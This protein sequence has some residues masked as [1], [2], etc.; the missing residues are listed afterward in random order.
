MPGPGERDNPSRRVSAVR[1][2][3]LASNGTSSTKPHSSGG[4][5]LTGAAIDRPTDSPKHRALANLCAA[6]DR[7]GHEV[8]LDPSAP[9]SATPNVVDAGQDLLAAACPS[10]GECV[11]SGGG[12]HV[13][14]GDPAIPRVGPRRRSREPTCSAVW[15]ASRRQNASPS[16][17]WATG[18]SATSRSSD[19]ASPSD[20]DHPERPERPE[21][22]RARP[23]LGTDSRPP[24][25]AHDRSR[26]AVHGK[27]ATV[28]VS[29]AGAC[30]CR[31]QAELRFD[32][33]GVVR[34]TAGRDRRQRPSWDASQDRGP[35]DRIDHRRRRA[36][37]DAAS[38]P[39]H[40][41]GSAGLPT[42][43]DG[44]R[45]RPDNSE[46]KTRTVRVQAVKFK[47]ATRHSRRR[48]A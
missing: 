15:L 29:C 8:T 11:A 9:G 21:R 4:K 20:P 5:V 23:R 35:R 31:M 17:G 3:A 16:I 40:D 46:W 18:S 37:A 24:G 47:L 6:V 39:Q 33:R 10:A 28:R 27:T 25:T 41:R 36:C 43:A 19:P 38:Q 12:G 34:A 42:C 22:L 7:S 26:A 13:V 30:R 44:E 1:A 45:R 2:V 48:T 32:R 14:Q